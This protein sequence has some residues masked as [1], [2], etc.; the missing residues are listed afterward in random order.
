MYPYSPKTC[1]TPSKTRTY[2]ISRRQG[3]LN[4]SVAD[5]IM[6]ARRRTRAHDGMRNFMKFMRSSASRPASSASTVTRRSGTGW[7]K[8]LA[9]LLLLAPSGCWRDA[10][11][12]RGD[13][14]RSLS[15]PHAD[16]SGDAD[17]A[18][19]DAASGDQEAPGLDA[20]KD[21]PA[22]VDADAAAADA[23]KK[24]AG[25]ADTGDKGPKDAKDAGGNDGT[26]EGD[27][28]VA[29]TDAGPTG[30]ASTF[31]GDAAA[32]DADI[33]DATGDGG[34][35]AASDT[36]DSEVAEVSS[37]DADV[38][39]G[40]VPADSDTATP[41]PCAGVNCL[42]EV[43]QSAT[44]NPVTGKCQAVPLANG[45]TCSD[46]SL[47]TLGDVCVGGTCLPG[48][49]AICNDQNLCTSDSCEAAEGCVF[50][51]N[52]ATCNDGN[53]CTSGDTCTGAV[54]A[55]AAVACNDG[56]ACTE[57]NCTK[58]KGCVVLPSAA[59]CNDGNACTTDSCDVASGCVVA[60]VAA[61]VS[62]GSAKVC[63]GA[64]TCVTVAPEGM[65]FIPAGRFWMGC[66]A[67]DDPACNPI[68]SPQH[69]VALTPYYIDVSEVTVAQYKKC[70]DAG[71]CLAPLYT[72]PQTYTASYPT[73]ADNPVNFITW[74]Q[75]QQYCK[76]RGAEFDLPTEAQWEMAARG[77]CEQ[78]GS[79]NGPACRAAMRK[80][81]WG[82]SKATCQLAVFAFEPTASGWAAGCGTYI[83]AEVGSVPLGDSPYGLHDMAG[84]IQEFTRDW[85]AP[86]AAPLASDPAGPASSG[87]LAEH[88]IRGGHYGHHSADQIS[89]WA[90]DHDIAIGTG[91]NYGFRCA[92]SYNCALD[93]EC[94]D[95]NPCNT[96]ICKNAK[97]VHLAATDGS[98]CTDGDACTVGDSCKAAACVPGPV[99]T[100]DDASACTTDSCNSLLGCANMAVN[101]DDGNACTID[102]CKA[103]SG[104]TQLAAPNGQ[105]CDDGNV[106]SSKDV[107]ASG[108][109]VGT[110]MPDCTT[111]TCNGVDDDKDGV[112]DN[113][114]CAG[115]PCTCAANGLAICA[116]S[117]KVCPIDGDLPI[118]VD[119]NGVVKVVCAHDYQ[120]WP[121][122]LDSPNSF[123]APAGGAVL[124]G[125]TGLQW[126][127]AVLNTGGSAGNGQLTWAEANSYCDTLVLTGKSDWRLPTVFE[128]ETLVDYG[129]AECPSVPEAF[130]TSPCG[131]FWSASPVLGVIQNCGGAIAWGV[132]FDGGGSWC[133]KVPKAN[134]RCV[135]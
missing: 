14:D 4:P 56:N 75:A 85:Y 64:A 111:E 91:A 31:D 9:M 20:M 63:D 70:V 96:E 69:E 108:T 104:C 97:C 22:V 55:G 112:T 76:W 7:L 78:N 35:D 53:A 61:G 119:D 34:G 6:L 131:T 58:D 60:P 88:P 116:P 114:Q 10:E 68:A 83:T 57:D 27:S 45:V 109:C 135:R 5:E 43:C 124:D 105:K 16:A 123:Q 73:F 38:A 133:A 86:Y 81:P 18:T 115:L 82:N 84:N 3:P 134:V 103:A 106:C 54:C 13:F 72:Y 102:G 36:E 32:G 66:N 65:A 122:A 127:Q 120:A 94:D 128:L 118:K 132:T 59:T 98:P 42:A 110:N 11:Q 80:F 39:F 100:C 130:G 17:V 25:S 33:K 71:V 21:A 93:A 15:K 40:D 79:S 12:V 30:D 24:D 28:A 23:T 87:T 19:Q 2:R 46:D 8:A 107:C 113:A 37:G 49:A 125:L 29:D 51:P 26:G 117:C 67:T 41:D 50:L 99:T 74:K 48:A 126:Q 95:G 89:S 52:G 44:C 62:C 47:C 121:V 129:R 92:R 101:C 90:R 77:S 1:R